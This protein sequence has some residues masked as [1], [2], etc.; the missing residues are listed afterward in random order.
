MAPGKADM[1]VKKGVISCWQSE[2]R[3]NA[4]SSRSE[5]YCAYCLAVTCGVVESGQLERGGAL[6][7]V[8]NE[9][10]LELGEGQRGLQ[11]N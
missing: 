6:L 2:S 3:A 4:A 8:G 5:E 9:Q 1:S 7:R 10:F 11:C